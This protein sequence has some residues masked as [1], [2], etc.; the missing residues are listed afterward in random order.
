MCEWTIE[1]VDCNSLALLWT[2]YFYF[3]MYFLENLTDI[4][5]YGSVI[6]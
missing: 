4:G 2:E 6:K 5:M 3:K 1:Y